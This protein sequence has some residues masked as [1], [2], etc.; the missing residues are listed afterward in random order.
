M[1]ADDPHGAP[2]QG[3][4]S[5]IEQHLATTVVRWHERTGD[6][7]V[8]WGGIAH[9]AVG[10]QRVVTQHTDR[11]TQW[12][13]GS[14]LRERFGDAY[15][16]I[17]ITFHHGT[18]HHGAGVLEVP[19]PPVDYAEHALSAAGLPPYLLDLRAAAPEPV[20]R[21]LDAPTRTRLIGPRYDPD[22]DASY[23]LSGQSPAEWF[24]A[25]VHIPTV[26]PQRR[27]AE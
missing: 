20:R 13:A 9:T 7:I 8:Y 26:T 5:T 6:A 1:E 11:E 4:L 15:R 3:D 17:G 21:W 27:F 10:S 12:N 22:N 23:H 16:S 14:R 18:V 19:A 2:G 25:V 24:D